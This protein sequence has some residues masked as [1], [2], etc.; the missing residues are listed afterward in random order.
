MLGDEWDVKH[1]RYLHTLGNLTL[2][3]Y[4][5]PIGNKSYDD[6]RAFYKDSHVDLNK[7]FA[8]YPTWGVDEIRARTAGLAGKVCQMWPRPE[9]ASAYQS[10]E[11]GEETDAEGSRASKRNQ[12]YWARFIKEWNNALGIS[13]GDPST[14][15][16]QLIP[17]NVE[18]T[19]IAHLWTNKQ[20]RRQVAF[21]EFKRKA[22]RLYDFMVSQ[23]QLVDDMVEGDI[24]WDSPW[25]GCFC[26]VED[27]VSFADKSDWP[28][29]HSWFCE[30]L[31][32]MVLAVRKGMQD[33]DKV[34]APPNVQ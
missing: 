1:E 20:Q 6:K 24:I 34:T 11:V 15:V 22:I 16:S 33:V 9:G 19:V 10:V 14:G 13:L 26:V 4:N 25:R 3:A 5:S 21:V 7:Y 2:T 30:E 8:D 29:Q 23:K 12:E 18:G 32:D 27:D 31:E 17:L 28:V